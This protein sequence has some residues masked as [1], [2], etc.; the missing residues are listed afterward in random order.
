MI[1]YVKYL[2]SY[3]FNDAIQFSTEVG[4]STIFVKDNYTSGGVTNWYSPVFTF[5]LTHPPI[6][7]AGAQARRYALVDDFTQ[8]KNIE[9]FPNA[10]TE[11]EYVA[12]GFN[13][14]DLNVF[15]N[16]IAA[17][18]GSDIGLGVGVTYPTFNL[19]IF[20]GP[21]DMYHPYYNNGI[22]YFGSF[23]YP[24]NDP[25]ADFTITL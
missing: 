14:T 6:A 11:A 8:D 3:V 22:N 5:N 25:N 10:F 4:V 21:L 1:Y 7:G 2:P 24:G 19:Y 13:T 18:Y 20:S 17:C 16:Q 9:I 23:I 12:N 15:A